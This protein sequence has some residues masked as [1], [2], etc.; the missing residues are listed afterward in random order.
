[1][2][3]SIEQHALQFQRTTGFQPVSRG[4]GF[5]PVGSRTREHRRSRFN[6]SEAI[7]VFEQKDRF[8]LAYSIGVPI[9]VAGYRDHRLEADATFCMPRLTPRIAPLQARGC[10]I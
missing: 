6:K 7:F 8:A 4:T 3:I 10:L 5:E 9:D 1:M 2:P